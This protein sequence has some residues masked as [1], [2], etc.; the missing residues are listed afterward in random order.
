MK[1][2]ANRFAPTFQALDFNRFPPSV[3]NLPA[4]LTING[5]TVYPTLRYR[6]KDAGPVSWAPWG[7]GELLTLQA[8]T[9]P[10]YNQGSPLLGSLDDSVKFNGGGYYQA[11]NNSF[12]DITT[13]DFV[14]ELI[15]RPT[16]VDLESMFGKGLSYGAGHNAWGIWTYSNSLYTDLQFDGAQDKNIALATTANAW[17]H[18][19]YFFDR[20]GYGVGYINGVVGSAVDIS[21]V[22]NL[23]CAAPLTI[24]RAQVSPNTFNGPFVYSAMWKGASWLDT[25]LQPTIAANRYAQLTRSR[26][27]FSYSGVAALASKGASTAAHTQRFE[28]GLNKLYYMGATTPRWQEIIDGNGKKFRGMLNEVA[29]TNICI[30]SELIS[31]G[32]SKED[33]G[34]S[35]SAATTAPNGQATA[36]GIIGDSTDGRH[37]IQIQSAYA[38]NTYC[39]SFF[40]KAGN[41]TWAIGTINV[42]TAFFNLSGAGSIG[43]T[44]GAG[45]VSSGI[46]FIGN[47]WYRCYVVSTISVGNRWVLMG[48]AGG[49]NDDTFAGD[50]STVNAYCWG[51]QIELGTYPSSYIPT[52][53]S[54]VTRTVDSNYYTLGAGDATPSQGTISFEFWAPTFTPDVNRYLLYLSDTTNN[55][56]I[57]LYLEASTG[58][59]GIS[60]YSTGGSS[61]AASILTSAS[62]CDNLVHKVIVYWSLTSCTLVV[63][64]VVVGTDVTF[65]APTAFSRLNVGAAYNAALQSG[66]ALVGNVQIYPVPTT[67]I[68]MP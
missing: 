65:D 38:T 50:G 66:P 33:A 2:T 59:L 9:A 43:T 17:A 45:Y 47:G 34:D 31:S 11:G 23:T 18:A 1:Y 39:Y 52:V 41:Q 19:L 10:D 63:D 49:D 12:A 13:E 57:S 36:L 44:G 60:S 64:G 54:Y 56:Q 16:N 53:A 51:A 22:T 14:I 42:A 32:W 21:A 20:S 24:G 46:Q 3:E 61:Q 26:P 4:A 55:N 37:F 40:A 35:F 48:P 5:Q 29:G 67:R 28:G 58:K 8:G 25:H 15:L 27:V 68:I 30:Y 6:G 62:K 7:Y